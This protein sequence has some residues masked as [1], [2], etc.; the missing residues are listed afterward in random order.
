M[1][2]QFAIRLSKALLVY[3]IGLFAVLAGSG[4]LLE[5]GAN[6]PFVQHVLSMDTVFPDNRLTWRAI[7]SPALHQLAFWG[8]V[9][10]EL[11]VAALCLWGA[12]RLLLAARATATRFNAAKAPSVA[13]L[14]LGILLWFTGFIAVGGEWFLMWQSEDWNGIDAAFRF[15][16]SL[17]LTLLFVVSDDRD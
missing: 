5:P 14:T 13:G 9:L 7:T 16:T 1:T 4:N 2:T 6:L 8:I 15:S 17:F 11:A 3:S 12:V 10:V